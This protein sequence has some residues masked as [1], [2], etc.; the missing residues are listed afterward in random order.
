M[1]RRE[2]RRRV[3]LDISHGEIF[4]VMKK[5][6]KSGI[7]LV[8]VG[9]Y[10]GSYVVRQLRLLVVMLFKRFLPLAVTRL[11]LHWVCLTLQSP[12]AM[13]LLPRASRKLSK[14][15]L[16][17][18]NTLNMDRRLKRKHPTDLTKDITQQTRGWY[19]AGGSHQYVNITAKKFDLM[20]KLDKL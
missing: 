16:A 18:E 12:S 15:S 11:L 3:D 2:F 19:P 5:S 1:V 9:Q 17:I 6:S 8:S 14:F 4:L 10:V 20:F 7:L 13:N